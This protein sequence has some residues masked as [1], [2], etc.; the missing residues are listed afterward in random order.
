MCTQIVNTH[1][2]KKLTTAD[3]NQILV[4][5]RAKTINT[6]KPRYNAPAF[7]II[8]PIKH[9]NFDL[10]KYFHSYLHVGNSENLGLKHNFDQSL[11]MR[12]SGV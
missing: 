9:K 4:T 7:I 5:I 1:V 3:V 6:V 8:P 12:D 11:E 2:N 10:K